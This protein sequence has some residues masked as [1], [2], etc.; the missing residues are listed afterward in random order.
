[1][2]L[3]YIFSSFQLSNK[4]VRKKTKL[5]SSS[6]E[7]SGSE[8]VHTSGFVHFCF[9]FELNI[10]NLVCKKMVPFFDD[11]TSFFDFVF[12]SNNDWIYSIYYLL[13]LHSKEFIFITHLICREDEN[14]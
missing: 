13:I 11:D 7:K 8:S 10:G 9:R 12:K 1:M 3:Y 4:F 2:F 14:Y 6:R 5:N